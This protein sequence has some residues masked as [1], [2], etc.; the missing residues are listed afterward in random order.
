MPV[1]HQETL[2]DT[3]DKVG[4]LTG[5]CP[6]NEK[7]LRGI[8]ALRILPCL[9]N[10]TQFSQVP[11]PH[12]MHKAMAASDAAGWVDMMDCERKNLHTHNVYDPQVG[13]YMDADWGGYLQN[14][15]LMSA[16]DEHTP[17]KIV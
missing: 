13:E 16:Q 9:A 15:T 6:T 2:Y 8:R 11:G 5:L 17:Y 10:S 4:G 7:M 1:L 14:R 12:S 3:K